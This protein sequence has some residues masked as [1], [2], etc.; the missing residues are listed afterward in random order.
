MT[1][2]P[3][4]GNDYRVFRRRLSQSWI[5]PHLWESMCRQPMRLR[6]AP[7]G[8]GSPLE[9]YFFS[10][11]GVRRINGYAIH[12]TVEKGAATARPHRR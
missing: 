9:R 7:A 1:Y 3:V 11:V 2:L 8:N 10:S 12:L 6:H 4:T 5:A